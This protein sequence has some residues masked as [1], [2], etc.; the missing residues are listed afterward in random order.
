MSI[1][2]PKV[3]TM[4]QSAHLPQIPVCSG[5]HVSWCPFSQSAHL[6][7]MPTCPYAHRPQEFLFAQ[8]RAPNTNL[9]R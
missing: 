1:I 7:P 9:P 8:L 4:L 6:P 3:P 2:G 5:A